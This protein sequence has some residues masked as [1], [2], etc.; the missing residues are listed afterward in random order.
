MKVNIEF[1][2]TPQEAREFL[3]LPDVSE[4]NSMYVESITKAMKGVQNPA[5]LQEYA[6]ALAPMGQMG[7]KMFQSFVEGGM[8]GAGVGGGKSKGGSDD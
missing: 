1:D 4:A 5:Q 3:G 2:C 8:R 6:S 7:L